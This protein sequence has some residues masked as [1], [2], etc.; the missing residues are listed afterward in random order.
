MN[1]GSA[2]H[3][4][5]TGLAVQTNATGQI[6]AD[7]FYLNGS[8]VITGLES[9]NSSFTQ[10]HDGYDQQVLYSDYARFVTYG[11]LYAPIYGGLAE[12]MSNTRGSDSWSMRV[13]ADVGPQT[14]QVPEPAS[15]ALTLAGLVLLT[16]QLRSRQA[17]Q[18]A[19][20]A[21][22]GTGLR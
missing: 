5:L 17:A 4:S 10:A 16:R 9:Y 14:N 13:A 1:L 18:Q 11:Y 6:L 3:G 2:T 20:M 21:V 7:V 15:W 19:R 8:T 22:V 12:G